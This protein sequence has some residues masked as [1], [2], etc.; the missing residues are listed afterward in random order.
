MRLPPSAE[1]PVGVATDGKSVFVT[2]FEGDAMTRVDTATGAKM[3]VDLA[4][5][6]LGSSR[7]KWFVSRRKVPE[8]RWLPFDPIAAK[9]RAHPGDLGEGLDDV[10]GVRL[11]VDAPWHGEANEVHLGRL[12]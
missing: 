3:V 9:R 11:G 7:P 12:F 1:G 5:L 10:V 2:E 6:P 4:R 8:R